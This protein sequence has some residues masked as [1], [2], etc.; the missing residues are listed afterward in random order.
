MSGRGE[1]PTQGPCPG[2]RP[3]QDRVRAEV[4]G[5]IVALL[6]GIAIGIAGEFLIP[7]KHTMLLASNKCYVDNVHGNVFMPLMYVYISGLPGEPPTDL[8]D[9]DLRVRSY[10]YMWYFLKGEV[11][12]MGKDDCRHM[13]DL[14]EKGQR[15]HYKQY[16]VR[17]TR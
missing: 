15:E 17:G 1:R 5:L 4:R 6:L 11:R 8:Y 13:W 12:A 9:P 10:E 3:R 14:W 16:F 7:T 2:A